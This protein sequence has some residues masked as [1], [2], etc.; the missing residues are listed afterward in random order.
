VAR[1]GLL[2]VDDEDSLRTAMAKILRGKG[3][4]V[5]EATDGESA[6]GILTSKGADIEVILLDVT[7]PGKSGAE[8]LDELYRIRPDVRVILSTAYRREMVMSGFEGREVWGF[9]RKP[10]QSDELVRL[11]EQAAASLR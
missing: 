8:L 6:I 9:I 1:G 4:N 2:F 11:L 7:L 10:Y 3:F 5:I